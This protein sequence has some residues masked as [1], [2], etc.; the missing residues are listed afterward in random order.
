MVEWYAGLICEGAAN[1]PPA[2]AARVSPIVSQYAVYGGRSSV[3]Q[4]LSWRHSG[5]SPS[6]LPRSCPLP[7]PFSTTSSYFSLLPSPFPCL[8]FSSHLLLLLHLLLITQLFLYKHTIARS[9]IHH[10]HPACCVPCGQNIRTPSNFSKVSC[11]RHTVF[12]HPPTTYTGPLS[13]LKYSTQ[14]HP[15]TANQSHQLM[16]WQRDNPLSRCGVAM[17]QRRKRETLPSSS[18]TQVK[19]CCHHYLWSSL[20]LVDN[21]SRLPLFAPLSPPVDLSF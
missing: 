17:V 13:Q 6:F 2:A 15:W 10:L 18:Q 8:L 19:P 21:S 11:I 5:N 16:R 4:A 1:E 3:A 20:S 7:W 12:C 14:T 9:H